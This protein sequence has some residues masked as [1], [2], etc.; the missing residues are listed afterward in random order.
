MRTT[1][2]LPIVL[3][4]AG[5]SAL[6]AGQSTTLQMPDQTP[7]APPNQPLPVQPTQPP[8]QQYQGQGQ[9]WQ[10]DQ[11][12]LLQDAQRSTYQQEWSVGGAGATGWQG[13]GTSQTYQT[14]PQT[15]WPQNPPSQRFG[16][17][18][19]WPQNPPSRQSWP[20][21]GWPN[22]SSSQPQAQPGG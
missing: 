10:P 1:G 16:A 11:Q 9:L 17:P 12:L 18:T 3:A 5:L 7:A 8:L 22:S 13:G 21:T 14:W 20:Q 19:G 4:I 15:G 6:V 2:S